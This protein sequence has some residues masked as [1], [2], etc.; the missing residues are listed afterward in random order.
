MTY[1]TSTRG[2][3]DN[4][5]VVPEHGHDADAIAGLHRVGD[6]I[7]KPRKTVTAAAVQEAGRELVALGLPAARSTLMIF[8]AQ[9][10]RLGHMHDLVLSWLSYF[11]NGKSGYA[12]PSYDLLAKLCGC[13]NKTIRNTCTE[14]AAWGYLLR[15]A[16]NEIGPH[17]KKGPSFAIRPG[18][19]LDWAGASGE[20]SEMVKRAKAELYAENANDGPDHGD[21][22]SG[23]V[24]DTGDIVGGDSDGNVPDAGDDAQTAGPAHGD[25]VADQWPH[26]SG[27][28]KNPGSVEPVRSEVEPV[29]VE[30]EVAPAV[31]ATLPVKFPSKGSLV[32][33]TVLLGDL[34]DATLPHVQLPTAV[35]A[36]RENGRARVA[37][38]AVD[39]A[40][41]SAL[42]REVSVGQIE[43]AARKAV[44]DAGR[45][46]DPSPGE[47]LRFVA[48]YIENADRERVP[49]AHSAKVPTQAA[50]QDYRPEKS[51]AH[52]A[53]LGSVSV[54]AR[55]VVEIADRHNVPYREV[56]AVVQAN[57][58]G[59]DGGAAVELPTL[60]SIDARFRALA[61]RKRKI[62]SV[63]IAAWRATGVLD[64]SFT[65]EKI[66][67]F[68]TA[69]AG[70]LERVLAHQAW[71]D[72]NGVNVIRAA[73]GSTLEWARWFAA[74]AAQLDELFRGIVTP[75]GLFAISIIGDAAFE[76]RTCAGSSIH[77][78]LEWLISEAKL[79]AWSRDWVQELRRVVPPWRDV[80]ADEPLADALR[81][82]VPV[83]TPPRDIFIQPTAPPAAPKKR[84]RFN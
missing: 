33:A 18:C 17:K 9:D 20:L 71:C 22:S 70:V 62:A 59:F 5:G 81:A 35:V 41:R 19:G 73:H 3:G 25:D 65:D 13:Q 39:D 27:P 43:V 23:N 46:R 74:H 1:Q 76:L 56:E 8:A 69:H 53:M 28:H 30:R 45:D 60:D 42:G 6:E 84:V 55:H 21:V 77:T 34:L 14:L 24:P 12:F 50:G 29:R 32:N 66:A 16:G 82:C 31:D 61:E 68:V 83:Y 15:T 2:I 80:D 40:I 52:V 64:P 57:A 49:G 48:R 79:T 10:K 37:S 47:V 4:S 58:H 36:A 38:S 63:D 75:S 26:S 7:A 67:I 11:T 72:Q 44:A 78:L 51:D 54:K